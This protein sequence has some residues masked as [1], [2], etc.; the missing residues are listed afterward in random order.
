MH[1]MPR[2]LNQNIRAEMLK[3]DDEKTF[4]PAKMQGEKQYKQKCPI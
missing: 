2:N 3:M 1:P 4:T